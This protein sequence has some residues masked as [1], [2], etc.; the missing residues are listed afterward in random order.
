[1]SDR[2]R[3]LRRLMIDAGFRSWIEVW[4]A[5]GVDPEG[6]YLALRGRRG[7]RTPTVA[8]ISKVLGIPSAILAAALG[9]PGRETSR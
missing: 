6:P 8:K 3:D 7:L 1:M 2:E 5:A 4:L 9:R